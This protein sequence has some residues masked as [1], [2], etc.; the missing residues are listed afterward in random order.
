MKR[1]LFL[2]KLSVSA[3]ILIILFSINSCNRQTNI[4]GPPSSLPPA[5]PLGVRIYYASDGEITVEWQQNQDI[6]LNGYN[7]YRK[8]DSTDFSLIFFTQNDYYFDDSL[9]YNTKYIYAISSVDI[10]GRESEK[11]D[12][13][14]AIPINRYHPD[15]PRGVTINARNW[16]GVKYIYLEWQPDFDTDVRRYNIY[17]SINSNFTAD[18]SNFIG[19][20]NN[21]SFSDSLNLQLYTEYFYKIKAVDNGGL[22]SQ[23]SNQVNDEILDIPEIIF[24]Q[25]SFETDYFSNF[26]I[27]ALDKPATYE[28]VVQ[29]NEYFGEFYDKTIYTNITNDTLSIDFSPSYL[30][31][32]TYYWR[33]IT[34]SNGSEPNSISK[35]YSFTLKPSN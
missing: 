9:D 23:E 34:Y 3:V 11:S 12:T 28:V 35:L 25:D 29:R 21:V 13:V 18:T 15:T 2:K 30:Y 1:I 16:V 4:S 17:R 14:S 8:T 10:Y 6:N 7:V 27:M 19:F 33:V 22:K 5:V 31:Y 26:L 20:S 32:Q 24:P